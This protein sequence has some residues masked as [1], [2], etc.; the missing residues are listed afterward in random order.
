M[1]A[2]A[3]CHGTIAGK[4]NADE[5]EK[6]ADQRGSR[7]GWGRVRTFGCRVFGR[8]TVAMPNRLDENENSP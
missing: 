1:V 3:R 8:E 4:T 2:A 7:R 6:H 5:Q